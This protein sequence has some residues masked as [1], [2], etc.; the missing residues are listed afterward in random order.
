MTQTNYDNYYAVIMAGGGGTRL[1]PLSRRSKPKQM[2][3]LVSDDTLFQMAVNRLDGLFPPER[4]LVVTVKDQ[5]AEMQKQAQQI[6]EEN[7]IIE[8]MPR[9]TASVV[10]LASVVISDRDPNAV[11][12]VLTADHIITGEKQFLQ[13]LQ[14]AY[15]AAQDGFLVTLGIKPTFPSTGYGYIQQG[16][17]LDEYNGTPVYQVEKFREKPAREI[18]EKML[19]TGGFTW[20]SGMFIWRVEDILEEFTRQMPELSTKLEEI[21]A[22]IGKLAN[23]IM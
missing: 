13:Y 5:A 14:S 21:S 16:G 15:V 20:N 7:I 22:A 17:Y 6:P 12:A 8:S 19:E 2:L 23:A 1:W 9:G 10:G 18:A 11:M 4:I 3:R